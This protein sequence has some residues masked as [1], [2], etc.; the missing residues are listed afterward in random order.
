MNICGN[1]ICVCDNYEWPDTQCSE[2]SRDVAGAL[3]VPAERFYYW[4]Q[5]HGIVMSIDG[6][7]QM[8]KNVRYYL[9]PYL[10]EPA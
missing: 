8:R 4:S 2:A 1:G 6:R 7:N 5:K 9:D 10:K 3:L